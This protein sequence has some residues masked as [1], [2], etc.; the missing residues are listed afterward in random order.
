[1]GAAMLGTLLWWVVRGVASL[2]LTVGV[3]SRRQGSR[4]ATGSTRG[5]WARFLVAGGLV[6]ALSGVI[7]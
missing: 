2:G 4:P 1:M 5:G 3:P 6:L 7:L